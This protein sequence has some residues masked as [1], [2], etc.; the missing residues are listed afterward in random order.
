M[1]LWT[2]QDRAA[3]DSLCKKGALRC[4]TALAEWLT[5]DSFKR[6]YDWLVAEMKARIGAPPAGVEYPIWAWYLLNGK[7]VK[8]D[9]RRAEFRGY[10]GEQYVIEVEIPDNKVLL[11]DEEMWHITLGDGYFNRFDNE[12]VTEKEDKWFDRLP[13][14]EQETVKRKSWKSVFDQA[15]CP[16]RFVQATFWELRKEQV[17]STR[18]FTGR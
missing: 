13:A 14:G 8:P 12:I 9:L 1:R 10:S 4:D 2:I 11:S 3:Y 15:R 6:A 18:K 16:W 17:V 5:E 7:N